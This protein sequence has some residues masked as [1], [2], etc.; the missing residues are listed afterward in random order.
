DEQHRQPTVGRLVVLGAQEQHAP[1]GPDGFARPDLLPVDAVHR[2]RWRVDELA[3]GADAGE[4]ASRVRL[5]EALAPPHL[6]REHPRQVVTLLLLA[7][8]QAD[9]VGEV[10][11]GRWWRRAC[12]AELVVEDRLVDRR[13]AAPAVLDREREAGP[14]G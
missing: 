13:Q 8:E 3:T 2:P 7:A 14:P 5:A 6:A 10:P 1:R 11:D 4:I 12:G 9:R